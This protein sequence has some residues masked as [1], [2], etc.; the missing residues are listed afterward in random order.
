MKFSRRSLLI[1][2]AGFTAGIAFT[3]VPWKLLSDVSIWTQNWPWIPQ[4]PHGPVE[5][6][7]SFCTLCT[8]GCG[9]RVRLAAGFPVG[10]DGVRA[11]PITKGALCPLAFAAHQLNWHPQ[12][13]RQVHHQ[14]RTASWAEAQA[15][16][17]KACS[18]GPVLI[19]DGR[20]GRAASS[21]F[22]AFAAKHNGAHRVVLSSETQAL[23]PY[24]A[25]SGV[26][27]SALGYDLENARTIISFGAALLDGWGIPGRLTRL[28]SER[29][30]GAA[31]PQLRLIQIEPI[32][33][34]TAARAWQWIRVRE[35]TEGALAAGLARAL[36]EERLV[37]AEG[38][39]PQMTL[40]DA[41]AQ[42]GM[43]A[44]AIRSLARTM[45]ERRPT[46]VVAPDANP[47]LAALNVVLGA[48][49]APGG[50]VLRAKN[51]QSPVPADSASGS[52]RA[53]LI[54]STV[55]W[56]F[57]PQTGAEVFRF[58]AWDGGGSKA[59]WLLPAP[60][61]LEELTDVPTAPSSAADTYT[62]AP[63]LVTS[64][65]EV[66]SPT[67]F[68][69]QIDSTLPEI[70]KLIHA[71]CEEIFKAHLGTVYGE[72]AVAVTNFESAQKMEEQLRKGALWVGEP[73]RSPAFRCT[74]KEWPAQTPSSRATEWA[75]AWTPPVLP[76]LAAKLYQESTL[77]EV[78]V[79][80]E[81]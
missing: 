55:P 17:E 10:V 75:A 33:S 66:R 47:S 70:D 49:A 69:A 61:F 65:A 76:P 79:R 29:A 42:T 50:I 31:D 28:W 39:M 32:L 8:A 41:A 74:L 72:Q 45:V 26:P 23:T 58:A 43:N 27:A 77:R 19:L 21:I 56:E 16:F 80:R 11:N 37:T 38:P 12:R 35:G 71:R 14:G 78:P 60:G 73:P 15:A 46:L 81:A 34:R 62:I 5:T 13:L 54:D 7:E 4:P 6:K 67:Q 48:V 9:M 18:E 25:W 68:L 59:D 1:G 3:P 53:I 30:A 40:A 22:E 44:E 2:S 24:A 64:P 36:L 57:V 52:L 63:N 20:P 51:T